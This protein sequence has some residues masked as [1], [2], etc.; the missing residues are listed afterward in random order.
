MELKY[1]RNNRKLA[2]VLVGSLLIAIGIQFYLTPFKVLDGGILGISLIINYLLEWKIGL[3]QILCSI[4]I[5]ILAWYRNRRY[6]YHS[7]GGL[8]TSSLAIDALQPLHY[9]FLYYIELGPVTSSVLGGFLIG[10]GIGIMLR[11]DVSTG[12]TDLL[13]QLIADRYPINV[14]MAVFIIDAFIIGIGGIIISAETFLLSAISILFGGIATSLF[15]SRYVIRRY[16]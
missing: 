4:P 8:I 14:G 2:A 9:H 13:A 6:V 16:F 3:T 5:F 10:A 11:Y 12:G 7:A 1:M 15:S